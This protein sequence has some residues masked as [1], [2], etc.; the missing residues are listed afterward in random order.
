[1]ELAQIIQKVGSQAQALAGAGGKESEQLASPEQTTH[2]IQDVERR[3]A[4]QEGIG[5]T[6]AEDAY[7]SVAR[8]K[9]ILEGLTNETSSTKWSRRYKMAA[10]ASPPRSARGPGASAPT[11]VPDASKSWDRKGGL[12]RRHQTGNHDVDPA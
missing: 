11:M 8:K 10:C 7:S 2:Q 12:D 3:M 9:L 4:Q 6:E 5:A 1:M